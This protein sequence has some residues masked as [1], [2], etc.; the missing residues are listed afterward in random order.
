MAART[1]TGA[2]KELVSC[3]RHERYYSDPPAGSKLPKPP[4][5]PALPPIP[6][7]SRLADEDRL[8]QYQARIERAKALLQVLKPK[9]SPEATPPAKR[10]T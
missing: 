10:E 8:E 3:I 2:P 9:S 6:T 4:V 5:P 7:A 1:G